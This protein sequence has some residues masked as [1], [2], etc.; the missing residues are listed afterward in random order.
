QRRRSI[1]RLLGLVGLAKV[2][3][4][5]VETVALVRLERTRTMGGALPV[6]QLHRLYAGAAGTG[7]RTVAELYASSLHELGLLARGHIVE[8]TRA[9]LVAGFIGQTSSKT[10]KRIDDAMGGVFYLQD[11][12]S[13]WLRGDRYENDAI[14]A[15]MAAAETHKDKIAFVF[16]GVP[17][18]ISRMYAADAR[19]RRA[20]PPP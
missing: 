3:R 17:D 10:Q 12:P 14:D 15:I 11:A 19:V 20:F 5:V 6:F 9:D 18:D 1:D 2:K 13:L 16:S 7:K 8:V 4:D